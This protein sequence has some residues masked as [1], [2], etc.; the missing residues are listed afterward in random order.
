MD[1]RRVLRT[2]SFVIALAFL[3]HAVNGLVVE[4]SVLGFTSFDDYSD[5]AKLQVAIGSVPWRLSGVGHF[6]TSFVVLVLALG[7]A[8]RAHRTGYGAWPLI[9]ALGIVS[10]TGFGING[11]A[12]G[13]GAQVVHLLQ[14]RNP[15]VAPEGAVVTLS[16][17]V[18]LANALAIT[19]LGALLIT[20]S[21]WGR[22]TG[23]LSTGLVVLGWIAGVSGLLMAFAYVPAYLLL[24]LVWLVW[25]GLTVGE[26]AQ[27]G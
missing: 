17:V 15:A 18:P 3:V 24:Y 16:I 14:D 23:S 19:M 12:N 25:F 9:A 1:T 8:Q 6:V 7:L 21:V 11:A 22:R 26:P 20:V 5:V 2:S 4:R 10:A 27:D 13:L